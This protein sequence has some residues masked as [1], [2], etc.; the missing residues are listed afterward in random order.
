MVSS[1]ICLPIFTRWSL[2][3]SSLACL[4]YPG[5]QKLYRKW[6]NTYCPGVITFRPLAKSSAAEYFKDDLNRKQTKNGTDV[7]YYLKTGTT[8]PKWEGKLAAHFGLTGEPTTEHLQRLLDGY[9]PITGEDLV[10]RRISNRRQGIDLVATPPKSLSIMAMFDP[11]IPE[12][13]R[14]ADRIAMLEI[15][16]FA[17]VRVRADGQN[18]TERTG[19]LVWMTVEHDTSRE[20]DP[21]RHRH[22]VV[23]N[24]TLTADGEIKALDL[25][26]GLKRCRMFTEVFRNS[27]AMSL[28][29]CGYK[30]RQKKD[31]FEIEDVPESLIKTF[32]KSRGKIEEAEKVMAA[33]L[34]RQISNDE[35]AVLAK[36]VKRAKIKGKSPEDIREYQMAQIPPDVLARLQAAVETA[37][38]SGTGDPNDQTG[39][40]AAAG[41]S[42]RFSKKHIMERTSLTETWKVLEVALRHS[43]GRATLAQVKSAIGRLDFIREGTTVTTLEAQAQERRIL[44]FAQDG[45]GQCP[46][47]SHGGPEP[48]LTGLAPEQARLVQT[49]LASKDRLVLCEAPPGA[50][51]SFCLRTLTRSIPNTICVAPTAS[52]VE[53][54]Q[55]DGVEARTLDSLLGERRPTGKVQT[56][57]VDESTLMSVSQCCRLLTYA[58]RHGVRLLMQGDRRQMKSVG[59]GQS[60]KLLLEMSKASRGELTEIRRQKP[61]NYRT[62]IKMMSNGRMDKG[63]DIFEQMGALEEFDDPDKRRLATARM[64]C[65]YLE[66]GSVAA[67][68]PTWHEIRLSTT[69]IRDEL[70]ARGKLSR[71]EV[72]IET[73]QSI[74]L[75]VAQRRH[76]KYWPPDSFAYFARKVG[77]VPL[78]TIGTFCG[79]AQDPK[80]G[81]MF[82]VPQLSFVKP[83]DLEAIQAVRKVTVKLAVGDKILLQSNGFCDD[84]RKLTNGTTAVVA[85]I[86]DGQISL[87]DGRVLPKTYQRFCLGYVTTAFSA[88]G[89]TAD[90]ALVI[91]PTGGG[92]INKRSMF[93][94]CSRGKHHIKIVADSILTLRETLDAEMTGKTYEHAIDITP[95]PKRQRGTGRHT[96]TGLCRGVPGQQPPQPN[97]EPHL[98]ESPGL[99]GYGR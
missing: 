9:H 18:H 71:D 60:F 83:D 44:A 66:K 72:E 3:C 12:L 69:A 81:F 1:L 55:A 94:A 31:S 87:A 86:E 59:A 96:D 11:R 6:S 38:A 90:T 51:K 73:L 56:V 50:G 89:S 24:L 58:E 91:A 95:R 80:L 78:G 99:G 32:S 43:R 62:A 25:N 98:V 30:L 22:H 10:K 61:K 41:E 21:L 8:P 92:G 45:I 16:N 79:K 64:Y 88:Q 47:L 29:A 70:R 93:V 65:D 23:P 33:E 84:G 15:E 39:S 7:D 36:D 67:V 20:L 54:L 48:D 57:I 82:H 4:P 77:K 74:D 35:R 28:L 76:T 42:A 37:K 14:E 75:S 68:A 85:K 27:L 5:V 53:V 26:E 40:D 49:V 19:T 17:G 63:F 34:G 2:R 13:V 46:P 52:A 97:Q